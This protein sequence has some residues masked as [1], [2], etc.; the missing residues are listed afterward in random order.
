M[1][2]DDDFNSVQSSDGELVGEVD[3][4]SD[5]EMGKFGFALKVKALLIN[6]L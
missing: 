2:S 6:D 5:G 4:D 3:S 1:D